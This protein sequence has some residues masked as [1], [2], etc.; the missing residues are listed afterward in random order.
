MN[1]EYNY[2]ES[3]ICVNSNILNSIPCDFGTNTNSPTN[4]RYELAEESNKNI[5]DSN[6]NCNINIYRYKFTDEFTRELY[7]FSKIH[8]YDQRK[9]FKEAW[10]IWIDNNRELINNEINRLT[11][12]QYDGDILDKMFKSARYYFRKKSTDKKEPKKRRDYIG[13]EKAFLR[14]IDNHILSNYK[15]NDKY[16]PSEGFV[17]FCKSNIDLLREE[18]NRLQSMNITDIEDIKNKIK[19]TYKN[20]YFM[21]IMK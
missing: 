19:K 17:D 16:K 20:R 14:S 6:A 1:N 8:Q 12:L 13:S 9:D 21:T 4:E 7:N 2:E 10:E 11:N 3:T 18:I 15:S 5:N